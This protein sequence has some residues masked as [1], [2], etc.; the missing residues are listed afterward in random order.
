VSE[1]TAPKEG[2]YL[3]ATLGVLENRVM[4]AI[5]D[6]AAAT[7]RRRLLAIVALALLAVGGT[8]AATAASIRSSQTTW[9]VQAASEAWQLM[10]IEGDSISTEPYYGIRFRVTDG[11]DALTLDAARVCSEAWTTATDAGEPIVPLTE[12]DDLLDRVGGILDDEIERQ[13][14]D[15][16]EIWAETSYTARIDLALYGG[17]MPQ[18]AACVNERFPRSLY[19][20]SADPGEGRVADAAWAERCAISASSGWSFLP[21]DEDAE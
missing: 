14:L 13:G 3:E 8:T 18:M 12:A 20:I 7:H 1:P 16:T 2:I 9:T 19:V 6:R 5:D 11:D 10:C 17:A 15:D 21:P 4:T